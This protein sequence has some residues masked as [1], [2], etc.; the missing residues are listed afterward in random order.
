MGVIDSLRHAITQSVTG[1]EKLDLLKQLVQLKPL[2][3]PNGKP[4]KLNVMQHAQVRT[5][6]FKAWFGDFEQA[7]Q[8]PV[9]ITEL[10]GDEIQGLTPKEVRE[11]TKQFIDDLIANLIAETGTDTLR[12]T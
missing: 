11:N 5:P 1:R 3:A 8:P 4:S 7:N 2:L 10:A 6:E 9:T 12:N